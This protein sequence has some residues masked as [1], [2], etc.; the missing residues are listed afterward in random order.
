M[1]YDTLC[2]DMYGMSCDEALQHGVAETLNDLKN[3]LANGL[4]NAKQMTG[5]LAYRVKR[6]I[7]KKRAKEQDENMARY[8]ASADLSEKSIMKTYGK[9]VDAL[10]KKEKRLAYGKSID[11]KEGGKTGRYVGNRSDDYPYDSSEAIKNRKKYYGKSHDALNDKPT[12]AAK[13]QKRINEMNAH[14]KK[15]KNIAKFGKTVDPTE[16]PNYKGMDKFGKTVDPAEYLRDD[17]GVSK[18][19][20]ERND[21]A[22]KLEK[23]KNAPVRM[24]GTVK[25]LQR[26]I[27]E[28]NKAIAYRSSLNK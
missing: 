28:L 22:R 9:S 1:Y 23:A 6:A 26:K 10:E 8:G 21:L 7:N 27:E 24:T 19:I 3:G 14:T 5:K 2:R 18:L 4:K 11:P 12:G 15:L 20:A 17:N 13:T 25:E 16:T